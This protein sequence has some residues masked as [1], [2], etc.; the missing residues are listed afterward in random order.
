ML[1]ERQASEE[2]ASVSGN[3][4][5]E[6]KL[7][8]DS[9]DLPRVK[10]TPFWSGR[11]RAQTRVLDSVYF[12]TVGHDL[13]ARGFSLRIRKV[14]RLY[15]QTLKSTGK[16]GYFER[17]EFETDL[18]DGT[19]DLSL[20][21]DQAIRAQ[22]A[23][24]S[25][26]D[27]KPIFTTHVRR[28]RKLYQLDDGTAVEIALDEGEVRD[29]KGST[30]LSEIELELKQ[31]APETL[32][33]VARE[34]GGVIPVRLQ[35]QSKPEIGY[36]HCE[37]R[38]EPWISAGKLKLDKSMTAETALDSIIEYC[39]SHILRNDRCASERA[40]AEG[41]HQVRVGLRRLRS[42]LHLF[43]SALPEAQ[44]DWI[45][46][47]ARVFAKALGPARDLDVF[48]ESVLPPVAEQ[49]GDLG[50]FAAIDRAAAGLQDQ[51]YE[52]VKDALAS[53]RFTTFMI[54]LMRW[55]KLRSW[56]QQSVTAEAARLFSPIMEL[57]TP[58]LAARHR[59]VL[60]RGKGFAKL[61]LPERHEVRLR[62]KKLRY[63]TDF[64]AGLYPAKASK[65][66]LRR[67]SRLQ[68][69]L[70]HLNDVATLDDVLGRILEKSG[71]ARTQRAAGCLLGWYQR[72]IY[73]NDGLLVRDWKSF[74]KSR[75]FWK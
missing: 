47:E 1:D 42:G 8:A 15:R 21:E 5:I 34:I 68:D 20:I 27:L 61:T 12:D 40:H 71:G 3:T 53:E 57:S 60:K 9:K 75:P 56:R 13:R 41:V 24:I 66:Y 31:G 58:L 44:F 28:S 55:R 36:A 54:E 30:P 26:S 22:L 18:R 32:F 74:E 19:P 59:A 51:A 45:N 64:F 39:V 10:R 73:G 50:D 2:V 17:R 25:P 52:M 29:E 67:L 4:E 6:L 46:G 37:G 72:E 7:T 48:R 63:A 33:D 14:G 65:P 62:V 49:L 23:D 70:G 69:D 11:A 35:V 16:A 43:K 38:A